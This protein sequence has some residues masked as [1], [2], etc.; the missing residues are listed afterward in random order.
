[1]KAAKSIQ[2]FRSKVEKM[3]KSVHTDVTLSMQDAVMRRMPV[4][5]GRAKANV[6]VSVG[7][8]TNASI[9]HNVKGKQLPTA[10]YVHEWKNQVMEAKNVLQSLYADGTTYVLNNVGYVKDLEY[11]KPGEGGSKQ[12]PQGM[13]RISALEF[14]QM[15]EEA[16]IKAKLKYG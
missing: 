16:V 14:P 10:A 12:A 15:V 1:V 7:K 4:K 5:T 11:K 9:Y 6:L 8:P 2:N 3:T 13:F